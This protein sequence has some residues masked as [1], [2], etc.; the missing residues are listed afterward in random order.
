MSHTR[1]KDPKRTKTPEAPADIPVPTLGTS[2]EELIAEYKKLDSTL[3]AVNTNIKLENEKAVAAQ[4]QIEALRSQGLQIVGQAN[5]L[6]RLLGGMGVNARALAANVDPVASNL[7]D[8][9]LSE[10]ENKGE[11]SEPKEVK[12]VLGLK[13]RFA[14]R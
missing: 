13:N 7:A 3:A 6:G 14:D 12:P 10:G 2:K 8:F 11:V 5:V 9:P 1:I 4:Q